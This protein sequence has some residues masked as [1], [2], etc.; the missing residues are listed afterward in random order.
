M[1]RHRVGVSKG[2]QDCATPEPSPRPSP[3]GGGGGSKLVV[4]ALLLLPLSACGPQTIVIGG[5]PA[6]NRLVTTTI[7]DDGQFFSDRVALIDVSGLLVNGEM[8]GLLSAGDNPVALFREQLDAAAA[9]PK[10]RAVVLRIN[11]PGGAV[12]ATDVMYRDLLR[13][14]ATTGKPVVA[15]MMDVAASGGYYVACGADHLIA[16]P[17]TVTG[18]VGVILQTVN[19]AQGLAWIGVRAEAFTSGPNKDAGS[20]LAPMTDAHRAVLRGLVDD[21]YA[22]FVAVVRQRRPAID[23][24]RFDELTDGRVLTG[25]DAAEAGLVDAVGDLRDALAEAR[26]RAGVPRADVVRFH[27]PL[28][29]VGSPYAAAPSPTPAALQWAAQAISPTDPGFDYLWRP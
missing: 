23:P 26:R 22:Q 7:E 21:M 2:G 5:H 9:D 1:A 20:P 14:K 4:L 29:Y 18:S 19:V 10:V 13:F 24:Q 11:S 25:V 27:R 17:T 16:H 28:Q 15:C 6:N 12:T 8:P 3:R